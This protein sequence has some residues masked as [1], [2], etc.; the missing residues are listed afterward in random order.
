MLEFKHHGFPMPYHDYPVNQESAVNQCLTYFDLCAKSSCMKCMHCGSPEE[1]IV[2][3]VRYNGTPFD[4]STFCCQ[5]AQAD[6]E[7]ED[8]IDPYDDPAYQ[9]RMISFAKALGMIDGDDTGDLPSSLNP[10]DE[11]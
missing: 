4:N 1:I 2:E 11:G 10:F 8:E 5:Q 9:N 6:A 3:T 7:K